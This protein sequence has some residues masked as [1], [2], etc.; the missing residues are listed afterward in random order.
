MTP[1]SR[2]KRLEICSVAEPEAL[3][4]IVAGLGP[5]SGHLMLRPPETGLLMARGRICGEGRLF[6]LGEILVSRCV[7]SIEGRVGVGYAI[8][9]DPR[10]AELSAILDSLG[11]SPSHREKVEESLIEL[12]RLRE[13]KILAEEKET[14]STKVDFFTIARGDDDA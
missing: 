2:Q 14:M 1:M 12:E 13:E 4:R 5:V 10:A 3:E 11:E 7:L 8:S 6:N 9:P